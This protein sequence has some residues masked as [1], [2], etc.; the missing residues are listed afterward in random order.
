MPAT[1]HPE[2]AD[3]LGAVTWIATRRAMTSTRA[4]PARST[5]PT[6]SLAPSNSSSS[7]DRA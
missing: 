2:A 1:R 3:A 6:C 4:V 7:T 5:G